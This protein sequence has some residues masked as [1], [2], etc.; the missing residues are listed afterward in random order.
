MAA[1]KNFIGELA[2]TMLKITRSIHNP[3]GLRGGLWP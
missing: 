1:V 2:L 3:S